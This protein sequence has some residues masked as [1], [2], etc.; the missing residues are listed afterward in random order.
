MGNLFK[1]QDEESMPLTLPGFEH[2]NRYWDRT[3]NLCA[4]KILPGEYYVTKNNELVATVLGSC[5]SA[6]IRDRVRGI[7]GMNHFLLPIQNE[8]SWEGTNISASSRYGNYAMEH[9][10]NDILKYG[11]NRALLEVK[12]FGGGRILKHM[13]DIG[14]KNIAFVKEYIKIEGLKLIAENVGDIYP[15]KVLY[16]PQSGKVKMKK[17][18]SLHNDTIITRETQYI[19]TLKEEPVESNI[20]LF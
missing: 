2:I 8:D 6:C 14:N 4:A 20:D 15:R 16:H 9:L 19:D 7:G 1:N 17:L 18:L 11:G 3:H 5:V 10:I 13:T 12:I